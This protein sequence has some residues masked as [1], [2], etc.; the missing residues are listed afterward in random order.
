MVGRALLLL[1]F[2]VDR[3]FLLLCTTTTTYHE[4]DRRCAQL[5][6]IEGNI[7]N[8]GEQ[9]MI[10]NEKLRAIFYALKMWKKVF[11][12]ISGCLAKNVLSGIIRRCLE[13]CAKDVE[14][15]QKS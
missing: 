1:R 5:Q 3:V 2:Y 15:N 11:L 6:I 4:A 10:I 14:L 8:V 7:K 13:S 12:K 9:D